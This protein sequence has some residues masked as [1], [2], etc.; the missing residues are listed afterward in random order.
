MKIKGSSHDNKKTNSEK[1]KEQRTHLISRP[2]RKEALFSNPNRQVV[3][4]AKASQEL[5]AGDGS[6]GSLLRSLS[7]ASRDSAAACSRRT[8]LPQIRNRI[9]L[10]S[11]PHISRCTRAFFRFVV[12]CAIIVCARGCEGVRDGNKKGLLKEEKKV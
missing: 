10:P 3:L 2:R 7:A 1:K 6:F 9:S 4:W 5:F 12:S 8:Q 11:L